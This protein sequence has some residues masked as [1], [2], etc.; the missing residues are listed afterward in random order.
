MRLTRFGRANLPV[1]RGG[2]VLL[3]DEA[4]S[5]GIHI[6]ATRG[7]GKSTLEAI[8]AL[9][10]FLRGK[11]VVLFEVQGGLVEQLLWRFRHLDKETI[12]RLLPKIV[13]IDM[14]G[15]SGRVVGWPLLY[16]LPGE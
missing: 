10:D 4:R 9:G 12:K 14:S 16:S 13:Y 8:L 1:P 2:K 6:Q 11:P 5:S 3:R 15:K 7:S